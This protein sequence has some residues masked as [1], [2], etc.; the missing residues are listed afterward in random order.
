MIPRFKSIL[1]WPELK[2]VFSMKHG[3][4]E[5]FQKKISSF[6]NVEDSIIFPYGRSALWT[7]L[8]H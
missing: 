4:V 5:K 6:F 7:F 3:S 2:C 1:G 8:K